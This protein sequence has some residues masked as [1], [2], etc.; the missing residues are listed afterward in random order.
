MT[1]L[2]EGTADPAKT[3]RLQKLGLD[4]SCYVCG[5][6]PPQVFVNRALDGRVFFAC[7]RCRDKVV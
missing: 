3:K 7:E 6:K 1:H 4:V 5:E 2:L